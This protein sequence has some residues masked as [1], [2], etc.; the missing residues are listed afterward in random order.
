MRLEIQY[1]SIFRFEAY[2]FFTDMTWRATNIAN[3]HSNTERGLSSA[4]KAS[5][6]QI[7]FATLPLRG[8]GGEGVGGVDEGGK[9]TYQ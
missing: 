2:R 1:I 6:L 7:F 8:E 4:P 3:T 9:D 5:H